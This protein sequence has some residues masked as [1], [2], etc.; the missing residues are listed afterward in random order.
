MENYIGVF[1]PK[2]GY[3]LV[4]EKVYP[5][6]RLDH[7]EPSDEDHYK[8]EAEFVD[9]ITARWG[10]STATD[11][12]SPLN[13]E[14]RVNVALTLHYF[15]HNSIPTQAISQCADS[16][17]YPGSPTF[18]VHKRYCE[19][20]E[21]VLQ[22][23]MWRLPSEK[24]PWDK[25]PWL[26]KF[27]RGVFTHQDN[28]AY[29]RNLRRAFIMEAQVPPGELAR[30]RQERR[31]RQCDFE[32]VFT[33][34]KRELNTTIDRSIRELDHSGGAAGRIKA[35]HT[36]Q[37]K[38]SLAREKQ[39]L[40]SFKD[41][42]ESCMLP[43]SARIPDDD[44]QPAF[45]DEG[46][47]PPPAPMYNELH[48]RRQF[49][50]WKGHFDVDVAT[51]VWWPLHPVVPIAHNFRDPHMY[52]IAPKLVNRQSNI[53]C[54]G[55][56]RFKDP[57]GQPLKFIRSIVIF[58]DN[59]ATLRNLRRAFIMAGE[60]PRGEVR[61][62]KQARRQK[63]QELETKFDKLKLELG[64]AIMGCINALKESGGAHT[65]DPV[66]RKASFEREMSRLET[67][68]TK[69]EVTRIPES[70]RISINDNVEPTFLLEGTIPPVA[71]TY[72]Q[73]R[74]SMQ[75]GIWFD[76][77]D[78]DVA[79]TVWWPLHPTIPIA[80]NYKNGQMGRV[81][82][83]IFATACYWS[84]KN[85]IRPK[86][87]NKRVH[88]ACTSAQ[89]LEIPINP[90]KIRHELRNV[91]RKHFDDQKAIAEGLAAVIVASP[92]ASPVASQTPRR[93]A[94]KR[95]YQPDSELEED[96]PPP[97]PPLF[98]FFPPSTH[99]HIASKARLLKCPY[100]FKKLGR[101]RPYNFR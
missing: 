59:T 46:I 69:I 9:A 91:V 41:Q 88:D 45:F 2:P 43:D 85:Y 16:S 96:L 27:V 48:T 83:Q 8:P 81:M 11:H 10:R 97:P 77:F 74:K 68:K 82:T 72:D 37:E 47:V 94:K 93:G 49:Q 32:E 55:A 35:N 7:Y 25:W 65:S 19:D 52:G 42:I 67:I 62:D 87:V 58:H 14:A 22:G 50:I 90:A 28:I 61:V 24:T 6:P 78:V 39:H 5:I 12:N 66:M 1:F 63:Q 101:L 75:Y 76:H 86:L 79:T 36:D 100:P 31:D 4:T 80:Q 53:H 29:M 34:I 99:S 89:D 13:T 38:A 18:L 15:R 98:F 73:L 95:K 21:K 44:G 33:T 84:W 51:C 30:D 3:P 17:M 20:Q 64:T 57:S 71:P 70:A 60:T 56:D 40:Q 26:L 54:R 23:K 92:V